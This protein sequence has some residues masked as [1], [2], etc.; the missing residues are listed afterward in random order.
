MNKLYK[1]FNIP[2]TNISLIRWNTNIIT[3]IHSHPNMECN[4]MV[5]K[6]I[7]QEEV[8]KEMKENGY[9]MTNT[10]VLKQNQSSHINDTIGQ[11]IIKNLSDKYSWSI[12]YYKEL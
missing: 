11:H 7:I 2:F 6:G 10:K 8:F 5:L 3:N 4:F 9:H 12:H 1:K